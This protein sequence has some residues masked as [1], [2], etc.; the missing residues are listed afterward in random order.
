MTSAARSIVSILALV[1]QRLSEL[2][3]ALRGQPVV[4]SVV[5]GISP[6]RYADGDRIECY[7]DA[8]LASGNAVGWWLEFRFADGS[9]IVESSVQHN[10][11]R[12]SDAIL[13]L[14]T[15]FAVD[16]EDLAAELDGASAMLVAT[17]QRLDL[18]KL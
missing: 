10:T 18:T 12:G 11:E 17:A 16:D 8:E 3:R 5:S 13:G 14:P 9:W 2:A 1:G 15:R 7:V 4:R 6:R